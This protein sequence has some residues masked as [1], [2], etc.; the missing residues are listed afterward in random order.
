MSK[1]N[2]RSFLEE[3]FKDPKVE[4]LLQAQ[5]KPETDEDELK[6]YAAVAG[7]VGFD[8]TAEELLDAVKEKGE[9][10][11]SRTEAQVQGLEP[12]PDQ[13]LKQVAGGKGY[14]EC[15]S[16]FK[17]KENCW[18]SDGCDVTWNHYDL[19][20]CHFLGSCPYASYCDNGTN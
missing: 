1:E 16:T 17:D 18:F 2:A 12:M 6:I 11:A 7:Q 19:Y 10:Q 14:P 20:T 13:D 15:K 9:E 8:F 4:E 3:G 5:A